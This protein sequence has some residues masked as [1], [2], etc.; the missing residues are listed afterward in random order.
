[1]ILFYFFR[2]TR[3]CEC[4]GT[5]VSASPSILK[6]SSPVEHEHGQLVDRRRS[7]PFAT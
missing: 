3:W 5:H 6:L 7:T 1:V 2:A 4:G